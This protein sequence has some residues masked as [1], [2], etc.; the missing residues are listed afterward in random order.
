MSANTYPHQRDGHAAREHAWLLAEKYGGVE[1]AE[2]YGDLE[3]LALEEPLAYLIGHVPFLDTTIFLDSKPLIPR[4]ETEYWVEKA[5][6]EIKS[7]RIKNTVGE[8][9]VLDL[10]A[11]SG[12]IGVAVL[13]AVPEARV[14]FCEIDAGHHATIAKNISRN[15]VD[16][17]RMRIFG[18]N[19][20]SEIAEG[21]VYDFIL[22][23][24]P[25]IDPA[26]ADR[27]QKSVL[28]HEPAS[29]LFGGAGGMEYIARII[30]EAP[31][32]LAARGVLY[33][34]H[35]PEQTKA[36]HTLAQP[37]PYASR[38]TYQDEWQLDRYTRLARAK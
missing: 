12:C 16:S 35:E 32:H 18:G 14:D 4:P 6:G 15:G 23:N 20:F 36:L 29:A 8:P 25:Y 31:Q 33:I 19:L 38:E 26:R 5:I 21:T 9:Q 11:G 2:F 27:V 7:A 34:E 37:F 17:S 22:S 10:C 3:R 1:T 30:E 13:K 24:P 28:D